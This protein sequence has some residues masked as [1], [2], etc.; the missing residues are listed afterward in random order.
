VLPP[1]QV[2]MIGLF[3]ADQARIRESLLAAANVL[4]KRLFRTV[5][6]HAG[7]PV[8]D[9]SEDLRS[10]VM[11]LDQCMRHGFRGASDAT[12]TVRKCCYGG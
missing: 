10:V 8:T 4:L 1:R 3:L 7:E 12:T 5:A 9:E 2:R 6:A 11:V